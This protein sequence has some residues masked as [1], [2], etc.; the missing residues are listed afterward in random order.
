MASLACGLAVSRSAA[1]QTIPL[2][3]LPNTSLQPKMRRWMAWS[4][5]A[6]WVKLA[7]IGCQCVPSSAAH[8]RIITPIANSVA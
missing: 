4:A 1:G 5:G 7:L 6:A 2:N 8:R 3:S